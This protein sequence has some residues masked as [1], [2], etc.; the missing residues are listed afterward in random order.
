LPTL[1]G[2]LMAIRLYPRELASIGGDEVVGN[3]F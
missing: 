1:I 3:V 2:M